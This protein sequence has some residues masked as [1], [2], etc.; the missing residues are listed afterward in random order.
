LGASKGLDKRV[1]ALRWRPLKELKHEVVSDWVR[2]LSLVKA[3][4]KK[5]VSLLLRMKIV[6]LFS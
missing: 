6:L 3:A 5:Y 1:V 2:R 4:L